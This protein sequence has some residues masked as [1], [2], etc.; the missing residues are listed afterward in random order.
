MKTFTKQWIKKAEEDYDAARRLLE[1]NFSHHAIICFHFQQ[2][3]EKY[4]KALLSELEIEFIKTHDIEL[5]ITRFLLNTYP[6]FESV[7][8]EASELS[9]YGVMPRY[10]GD[11]PEYNHKDSKDA[12]NAF[13]KI[14]QIV[15]NKL[16]R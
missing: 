5:L 14:K 6:E 2:A 4:V 8:S 15:E 11:Y 16:N 10:P 3:A 1:S 12:H 9:V 13:L 7:L